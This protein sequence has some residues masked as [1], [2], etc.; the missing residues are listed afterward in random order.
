MS[1]ANMKKYQDLMKQ[2]AFVRWIHQGLESEEEDQILEEMDGVWLQ[3]TREE[4]D[5]LQSEKPTTLIRDQQI[6][7]VDRQLKDVDVW[8]HKGH[9]IR[10]RVA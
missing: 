4:Q 3:L 8:V 9:A 2:L 6:S 5:I 7:D 10:Q 1:G